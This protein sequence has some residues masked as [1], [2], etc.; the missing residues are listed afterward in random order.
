MGL[1]IDPHDPPS[2]ALVMTPQFFLCGNFSVAR[3]ELLRPEAKEL[4]ARIA[5]KIGDSFASIGGSSAKATSFLGEILANAAAHSSL[6]PADS[7]SPVL[8]EWT[9][10]PARTTLKIAVSNPAV[11]LFDP[12]GRV[13]ARDQIGVFTGIPLLLSLIEPGTPLTF[14]WRL[15]EPPGTVVE[16]ALSRHNAFDGEWCDTYLVRALRR[17]YPDGRQPPYTEQDFL[18]AVADRCAVQSVRVEGTVGSV[19]ATQGISDNGLD[20]LLVSDR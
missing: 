14:T 19:A 7:T 15:P 9:A 13:F 18:C 20:E 4:F 16:C 11:T 17:I 5:E 12:G 8:V 2:K 1:I 3:E 10:D 6:L